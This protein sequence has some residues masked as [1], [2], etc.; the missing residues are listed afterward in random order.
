M[1]D[2]PHQKSKLQC[3]SA[4]QKYTSSFTSFLRYYILKNPEFDWP[5]AYWIITREP[6]YCQIWRW[7]WNINNNTSFRFRLFP[8]KTNDKIFQKIQKNF[9]GGSFQIW[10][11]MNFP[12]IVPEKLMTHFSEKCQTDGE[13]DRQTDR[14]IA[15]IL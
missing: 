7:W 2:S 5:S 9:F 4:C 10:A 11:K 6:E 15:M 13:T 12:T 1:L 8:G 3:L 14:Q